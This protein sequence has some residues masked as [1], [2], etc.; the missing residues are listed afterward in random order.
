MASVTPALVLEG[1]GFAVGK[2]RRDILVNACMQ[3]MPGEICA[4]V[5]PSGSGKTTIL[6]MISGLLRPTAGSLTVLG[7]DVG[8]ARDRELARLR[9]RR[10]GIVFQNFHLLPGMT[11][12]ENALLP[13]YFGCAP[14]GEYRAR[15]RDLLGR[16]GLAPWLDAAAENLS[17]GQRQRVAIARALLLRP[18]L[19]LADEPTGNLDDSSAATILSL[20]IEGAREEG[21]SLLLATHDRRCLQ[22][23]ER[24]FVVDQGR[25]VPL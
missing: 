9:S 12:T 10:M 2:N 21:S 11:S 7:V 1:V 25:V 14:A 8:R 22:V 13:A 3:V 16:L 17:E 19:V 18:A 5:G 15:V 4:L 23:V 6:N 24:T 20:L